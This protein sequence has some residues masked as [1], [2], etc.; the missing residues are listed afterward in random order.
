MADSVR[1]VLDRLGRLEE[2]DQALSQAAENLRKYR[3][4]SGWLAT[5]LDLQAPGLTD[6]GR[7]QEAR[8]ALDEASVIHAN[9]HDDPIYINENLAARCHLLLATGRT[10]ESETALDGFFIK[11]PAPGRMSLTWVRGELARA[12]VDLAGQKAE[13]AVELASGVRAAVERSPSRV[14]FK[15]YEAE[16]SLTEGKGLVRLHRATGALPLLQRAMVL[17]LELYDP[18]LSP[19]IAD[20]QIALADCLM[21]LGE[22]AQARALFGQAKAIHA[23]HK[24]LGEYIARPLSELE[25]R[26]SSE[27]PRPR[28]G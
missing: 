1:A 13:H 3:P 5:V 8:T 15:A 9:I 10:A 4:G 23:R 7:Y 11:D 25:R 12:N 27:T 14:Y 28:Q 19:I 24:H 20:A 16:A 2:G 18:Q 21:D 6:M 17:S 26:L 22:R